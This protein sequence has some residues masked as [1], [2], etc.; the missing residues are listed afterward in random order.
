MQLL[1]IIPIFRAKLVQSRI[2]I[3]ACRLSL[4]NGNI[5]VIAFRSHATISGNLPSGISVIKDCKKVTYR[6]FFTSAI[7]NH[8]LS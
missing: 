1:S 8:F 7:L 2:T 5:Y 4:P 6:P 3:T